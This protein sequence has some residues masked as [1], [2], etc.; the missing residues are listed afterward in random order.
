MGFA[1]RNLIRGKPKSA[2]SPEQSIEKT[3]RIEIADN[4]IEYMM[5]EIYLRELAFQ[6]AIQIL[7]KMLGKCE[8]RT[9]LNGEEI[10][11]D[12]RIGTRINSSFLTNL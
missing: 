8:I 11:R 1:L 10:F 4:P 7:A 6:R 9:F 12:D 3:T 5:T 2:Q